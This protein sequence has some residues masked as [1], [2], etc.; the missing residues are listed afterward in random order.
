MLNPSWRW[1]GSVLLLAH[2]PVGAGYRTPG[3]GWRLP[4]HDVRSSSS[5]VSGATGDVMLMIIISR[6]CDGD[7]DSGASPLLPSP[8]PHTCFTLVHMAHLAAS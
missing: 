5:G 4:A 7:G 2:H 8:P 3:S 1:A 6:A